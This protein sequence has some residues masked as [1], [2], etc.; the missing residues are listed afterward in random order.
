MQYSRE[1]GEWEPNI[2]GGNEHLEAVAFL[3]RFNETV[4]G[5]Y[6][7][8]ITIAEESTSWPGVS[9]PT[10]EG[11]LGFGYKWNMGWMHDSLEYMKRDPL[12]RKYHH[13]ELM[14]SME[15]HFSEHFILPLSHDEVV[16]GKGSLL[17]KMPGDDWRRYANLR[18]YY[19]FMF[20]H[21]GKKLLFMGAELGS[22]MEW[23][24]DDQLDWSLLD[25]EDDL[26]NL[27]R[28]L[29]HLIQDLNLFYKG[30]PAL[31]Q[32]DYDTW[33]FSWVI[34]DDADQSVYAFLRRGGSEPPLLVVCNFTPEVRHDYRVGVPKAGEWVELLNT[35]SAKYGGSDVTNKNGA[36]TEFTDAHGYEQSLVLTLPPLGVA[37]FSIDL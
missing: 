12:Y 16:H 22:V 15:Y 1:D 20:A 27:G 18:A 14:F 35:D 13:N 33:G 30:S 10:Y 7:A 29:Q 31:Y 28:G 21:P 19:G 9:K 2:H 37:F 26:G 8:A 23:N 34:G 25:R 32:S 17:G 36:C 6:P 3:K 4:Y 24:H 5:H 11:G